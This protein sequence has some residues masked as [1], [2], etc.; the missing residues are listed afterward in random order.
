MT[1]EKQVT[2]LMNL[3][4]TKREKHRV[5]ISKTVVEDKDKEIKHEGRDYEWERGFS[6]EAVVNLQKKT[7]ILLYYIYHT[8]SLMDQGNIARRI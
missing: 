2:L 1:A 5:N 3:A 4:Y 8:F 6:T 7:L